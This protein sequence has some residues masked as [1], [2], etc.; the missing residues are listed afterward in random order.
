MSSDAI[1]PNR[2]APNRFTH[3]PLGAIFA[4][5]ALPIIFVMGMNGVLAVVD[6]VFLGVFVGADALA[7]VTLMFPFYM[8]VVALATLVST[9]M[10]SLLA[11]HLGGGRLDEARAVFAGAHGLALAVGAGLIGLFLA[12]GRTAT[13]L[14]ASG[15]ATL[16]G[17]S[18]TYLGIVVLFSP[19]LFVLAVNTDA[20]RTEGRVGLM[21]ATSLLVS[22]ANIAFN[23]VLIVV[24]GLGVAGSAYG[25]VM[26]QG[27]ALAI[28]LVFRRY[29]RTALRPGA[30][31]R[32]RPTT[33]WRRIL[34]L[35]APQS[36][37]F[38]GIALGSAAIIAAIQMSA[39]A[40]GAAT[41][42]AYGI[43][44]RIMTF[45][46]LPLLGLSQAL[47]AITG[48]NYGAEL[49]RRS[50]DSLR[51]GMAVALAYCLV[52]E[53]ALVGFARPIA[54]VFVDDGAVVGEVGRIMPV[55]VAMFFAAGPA[56][57]IAAYFQAIGDAGRAAILG[58]A[59]PYA[60]AIPLTFAL[61]FAFGEPG[62]WFA[63]PVAEVL[64]IGLTAVV[65]RLTARRRALRW[66]LFTAGRPP[67]IRQAVSGELLP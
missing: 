32:H 56:V 62:I 7:A 18:H 60:F 31:L 36:L 47:Q 24:A 2:F 25:T 35:G 6:A 17:M 50:D 55:M 67:V 46:F 48:N 54:G 26:A 59:K 58:L 45:V 43:V 44:T 40:A 38:I 61:A 8:L 66:G 14:A 41:V 27:L 22:L 15:S 12:F 16:A 9:G 57:M 10:A 37:N 13:L 21:A 52:A 33:A 5:T 64:L 34:A 1:A 39:G 42:S 4:R 23:F 63:S 20:L 53:L 28:V 29:G 65:L 51:L 19:L 11:R 30:L 3:G 49:W